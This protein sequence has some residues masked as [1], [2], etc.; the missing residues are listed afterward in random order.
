[1]YVWEVVIF[2]IEHL[3]FMY[4][5]I[6]RRKLD[7]WFYSFKKYRYVLQLHIEMEI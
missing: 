6:S 4:I 5:K 2:E 7:P 1:M 3:S